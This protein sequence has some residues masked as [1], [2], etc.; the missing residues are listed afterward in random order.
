MVVFVLPSGVRVVESSNHDDFFK[1]CV[2]CGLFGTKLN[3]C[4]TKTII[5]SMLRTLRSQWIQLVVVGTVLKESD[6]IGILEVIFDSTMTFEKNFRSV[7]R[8][9]DSLVS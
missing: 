2:W 7:S 9:S 5:V 3:T 1:V 6:D 4:N 8:A